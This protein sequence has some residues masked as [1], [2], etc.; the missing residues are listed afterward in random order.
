MVA[1][2][3]IK[4]NNRDRILATLRGESVDR[5]PYFDLYIDPKVIDGLYPGMSYEDFVETEDIDAVFCL[6]IVEDM[7]AVDWVDPDR[8]IYRDKWGAL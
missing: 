6:A 7:D 2:C 4:M 8:R 5:V 1:C 3:A